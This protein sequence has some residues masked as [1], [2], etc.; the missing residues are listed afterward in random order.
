MK[1]LISSAKSGEVSIDDRAIKYDFFINSEGEIVRRNLEDV[2][3]KNLKVLSLAEANQYYDPNIN[4]LII[5]WRADDKLMLSNEATDFFDEKRC[6][7]K[8]LPLQEAITYWNRYEGRAVGLF[9][10]SK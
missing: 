8:L 10:I 4:E 7:I 6:K 2:A 5:G 9:H 3:D 1:P